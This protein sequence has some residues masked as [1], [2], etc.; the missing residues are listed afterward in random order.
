MYKLQ[1]VVKE[2]AREGFE[3]SSL[4]LVQGNGLRKEDNAAARGKVCIYI[5]IVFIFVKRK[6]N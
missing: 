3:E 4:V 5:Y 6:R 1:Q 2:K